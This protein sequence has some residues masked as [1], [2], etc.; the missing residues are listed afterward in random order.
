LTT[1]AQFETNY[2]GLVRMIQA[3][4]PVM[5]TQKRG[6][7][8]ATSSLAGR[9]PFP[10]WGQYT[11]SKFAVEGLMETLRYEVAPLG[12]VVALVEPG[13]IRTPFY[14]APQPTAMTAYVPWR[15]R[16]FRAM[17]RIEDR[18]PGP[19]VVADVFARIVRTERP[20]LHNAVTSEARL[21]PLLKRLLSARA[22]EK[23]IRAG[24]GMDRTA[25]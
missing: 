10:F 24:F 3:V 2:F 11:A 16:F 12:I 8:A 25:P 9:I 5:R 22:F 20:N 15:D 21:L 17:K 1:R 14:A 7:I 4:L 19:E 18:A 13:A 6:L 23:S